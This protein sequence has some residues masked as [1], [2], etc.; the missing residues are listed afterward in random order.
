MLL[1]I[2]F[3]ILRSLQMKRKDNA[4]LREQ[5]EEIKKQK[6]LVE[7][8]KNEITDSIKYARRIQTAILPSA[9]TLKETTEHYFLL[10]L[11]RDIVSGDFYFFRRI[12]PDR[13]VIIVADCTGHGVPGAF[14]S[15]LGVSQLN[16]IISRNTPKLLTA[17][18]TAADILNLL[19]EGVKFALSQTGRE[20]EAR[21][22]MDMS[23]CIIDYAQKIINFAG[24]NNP[25]YIVRNSQLLELKPTRNPI[26]IYIQEKVFEDQIF[27]IQE[28]DMMYMF[29]D[30]YADQIGQDGSKFLSKNFKKLLTEISVLPLEEQ[31]NEL[32]ERHLI[33]RGREEQIDDILVVGVKIKA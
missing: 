24:A 1:I 20:G 32:R 12:S 29:S 28:E 4:L 31:L 33:F 8:Q 5:K 27:E 19:R 26:G 17:A 9:E 22:G 3:L 16:D 18:F 6:E 23:V 2:A 13:S 25:V 15:M 21:D 14:M 11:P 30:G 10:Y 7:Y